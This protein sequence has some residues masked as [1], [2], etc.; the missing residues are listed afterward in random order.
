MQD[1]LGLAAGGLKQLIKTQQDLLRLKF[2]T[3]PR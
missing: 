3:R 2:N 1:L